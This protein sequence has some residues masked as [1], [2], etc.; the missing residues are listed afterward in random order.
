MLNPLFEKQAYRFREQNGI[1]SSDAINLHSLLI[2]LDVNVLYSPLSEKFSGMAIITGDG[3]KFMMINSNC[4]IGRQNF[5]LAH[6]LYH[7]FVQ[8]GFKYY[9]CNAG[10]FNRRDIEEFNADNFAS[11]LL[12][13][14]YGILVLIPDLEITQK[15]ITLST[16]VKL[17]QYFGVSRKAMLLRLKDLNLLSA[18]LFDEYSQ[19]GVKISAL[20]LGYDL[21]LYSGGNENVV[22]GDYGKK[23]RQLFENEIISESH[24]LNL[25]HSIG[26]NLSEDGSENEQYSK[27]DTCYIN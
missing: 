25:L 17:E 18:K 21:A 24:Y 2:K 7:L 5:T 13:P 22:I 15:N 23:A 3:S 1:S 9:A 27:S 20:Q 26:K 14:E 19:L 8:T 4:S 11:N 6:E 16:I 12:M 10:A